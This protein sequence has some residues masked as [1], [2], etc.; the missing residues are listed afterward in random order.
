MKRLA[1]DDD[2][3]VAA[4]D[5]VQQTGRPVDALR[6]AVELGEPDEEEVAEQTL[7]RLAGEGRLLHEPVF[8]EFLS[9]PGNR[10]QVDF[11]RLPSQSS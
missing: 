11:Y 5:R 8:V 10:S 2:A 9:V 4:V 7:R 3:V 1:M 6:V